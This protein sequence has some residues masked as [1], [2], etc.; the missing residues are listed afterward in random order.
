MKDL[1]F[2][3]KLHPLI[4]AFE[5]S[6]DKYEDWTF[7]YIQICRYIRQLMDDNIYDHIAN[8]EHTKTSWEKVESLYAKKTD[9]NKRVL[10]RQMMGVRYK[11]DI[12]ITYHL[13]EF[14]DIVDQ[15]CAMGV[16][17]DNEIYRL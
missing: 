10:I 2:V 17:F 13:S 9:I 4:F 5:K 6:S 16:K 14:Q 3:K 8:I 1:L 7:E 12:P 11:N 15:L